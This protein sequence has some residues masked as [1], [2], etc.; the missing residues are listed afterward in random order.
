[1]TFIARIAILSVTWALTAAAAVEPSFETL[2]K[3]TL[4]KNAQIQESVQDIEIARQQLERANAALWPSANAVLLGAP[5]FEER[6][7]ALRSVADTSKWGPFLSVGV[8]VVQPLYTFGQISSYQKAAEGQIRANTELADM[9]RAEI[10]LQTKEFYYGY[11]MAT[12]LGGL[13]EDLVDTLEEAVK[14]A[15]EDKNKKRKTPIKPHDLYN[16]KTNLDDLKQKLLLAEASRKTAERAVGWASVTEFESLGKRRFEPEKFELKT[17]DEYLKIAKANRPEFR[18]LKAGQDARAALADAKR[19]Q[20]YPVLFVGGFA[21]YGWSPVRD[22]Q[23]SIYA[24]D[25]FNRLLGGVGLGLKFDLEFKRHAAESA[26][27][28]AEVMKLKAKENYAVPG[29]ELEVKKAFWEVEQAVRSLEIADRRKSLARKWFVSNGLGW[30]IGVT[31]AKDL[32]EALEGS[33]LARKN[34]IETVYLL[35]VSLARL[36]KAVGQEVTE[37]KYK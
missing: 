19:A 27:Q 23:Q 28:M 17:I 36:T 5:I 37:L 6:G 1:M 7:N 32:M 34:Y 25:P 22:R 24:N 16:L 4:E 29:I 26:E 13:V 15:E 31:A 18:A 3:N 12:A 35:N 11:L 8:Q 14:T 21:Q 10:V 9:K 2:L 30:S 20:S 33:G